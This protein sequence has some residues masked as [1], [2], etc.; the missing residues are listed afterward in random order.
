MH[1]LAPRR[2]LVLGLMLPLLVVTGVA[3]GEDEPDVV[4]PPAPVDV[5]PDT[6]RPL[7]PSLVGLEVTAAGNVTEVL[8]PIAFR[9]DKDGIDATVT[10]PEFGDDDFGDLD[11]VKEDVLVFDIKET[12]VEVGAPVE[13][14][15]TIG[16]FDLPE[17]ERV[18]D[19]DLDDRV[20]GRFRDVLV[21]VAD[22]VAKK[23]APR[24]STT[25][26][27][28]PDIE[29]H[30]LGPA[31]SAV[32]L[33]VTASGNV[34]DVVSPVAFNLD[35]DGVGGDGQVVRD[36]EAFDEVELAQRP[37]LVVDVTKTTGLEKGNAVLVT[38]TIREFD[39]DD[40]ERL[41]DVD[42]DDRLYGPFDEKLVIVA[43]QV[44]KLPAQ[45]V[46]GATTN[47]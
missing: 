46:G 17:A 4:A 44:T 34:T 12:D 5:D 36:D 30:D 21:I 32:G 13:V 29:Y 16:E 28:T 37:V 20:Y 35:K 43:D 38:G 42:L 33:E 9:I 27:T 7:E 18:F 31:A 26:T 23:P 3:C 45:P 8:A 14:S 6:T 40:A 19:V 25:T 11:L 15:G 10:E 22:N 1:S 24:E 41:F 39:V 47:Q 2:R